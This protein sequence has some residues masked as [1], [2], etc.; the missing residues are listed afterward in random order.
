[1]KARVV[2]D[3]EARLAE[4]HG[5]SVEDA[6]TLAALRWLCGDG[7]ARVETLRRLVRDARVSSEDAASAA[8]LCAYISRRRALLEAAPALA[9]DA[10]D[11][12]DDAAGR[13]ALALEAP[14]CPWRR[15]SVS[16]RRAETE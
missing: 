12:A 16:G 7:A 1:M 13:L 15:W 2:P 9:R 14:A 8:D 5:K 3:F 4:S 6:W 11:A 10:A